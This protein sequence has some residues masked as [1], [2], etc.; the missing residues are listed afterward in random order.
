MS[1]LRSILFLL[2]QTLVTPIYAAV[3]VALFWI[4]RV[5]M[6]RIAASWCRTNLL[7]ARIS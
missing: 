1:A 3:M 4:P 7:G 5:P 6:Y 2:Y